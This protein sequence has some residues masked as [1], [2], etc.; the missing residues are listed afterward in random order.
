LHPIVRYRRTPAEKEVLSGAQ[1]HIIRY[2]PCFR[3]G[4]RYRSRPLPKGRL[5]AGDDRPDGGRNDY[6]FHRLDVLLNGLIERGYEV[7]PVSTLMD[8]A[9]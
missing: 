8:N 6:L 2:L 5:R 4:N 1:R 9:R 7:V 3:K